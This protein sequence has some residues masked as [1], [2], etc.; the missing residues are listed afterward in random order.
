MRFPIDPFLLTAKNWQISVCEDFLPLQDILV[1]TTSNTHIVGTAVINSQ[2]YLATM[3]RPLT[4]ALAEPTPTPAAE[5]RRR[6]GCA[7]RGCATRARSVRPKR[8]F[9]QAASGAPDALSAC[10]ALSRVPGADA[11]QLFGIQ[12]SDGVM[13]I[14]IVAIF[15][16]VVPCITKAIH[17]I[18][19]LRARC[20]SCE[21]RC[22]FLQRPAPRAPDG[23]ACPQT[24]R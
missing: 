7:F 9:N 8:L 16:F 2:T 17:V 18:R 4:G 10:L 12:V 3:P 13:S 22:R 1:P 6:P 11:Q 21:A 5:R 19:K 14:F 23:R 24:C 15:L 20:A